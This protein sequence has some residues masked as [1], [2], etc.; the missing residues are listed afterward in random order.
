[1]ELN[2][3]REVVKQMASAKRCDDCGK[4]LIFPPCGEG[5]RQ[6]GYSMAEKL[7]DVLV[8]R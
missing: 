2:E 7:A 8:D 3:I 1:M 6:Q 5:H 4:Q